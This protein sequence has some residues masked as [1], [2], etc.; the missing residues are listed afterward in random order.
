MGGQDPECFYFSPGS[1]VPGCSGEKN[2]GCPGIPRKVRNLGKLINFLRFLKKTVIPA[3]PG[4]TMGSWAI[5]EKKCSGSK[6]SVPGRKKCSG[7]KKS[8]P[9]QKKCSGTK[10]SGSGQLFHFFVIL[11][12]R[13]TRITG[14]REKVDS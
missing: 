10:K 6:K 13:I 5:P 11:S 2:S 3:F 14:N 4:S 1:W 7:D 9:G 12:S 8:A